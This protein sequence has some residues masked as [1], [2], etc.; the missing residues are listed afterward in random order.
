MEKNF[1]WNPSAYDLDV[2][3]EDI[4]EYILNQENI[5]IIKE[6]RNTTI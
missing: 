2:F 6:T 1:D 3:D 5:K 4:A